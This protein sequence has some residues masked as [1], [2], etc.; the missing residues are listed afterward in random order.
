MRA[1]L[2][3]IST[4]KING[5]IIDIDVQQKELIYFKNAGVIKLR[6]VE[7]DQAYYDTVIVDNN[8]NIN[9][10]SVSQKRIKAAKDYF[11]HELSKES[12]ES[13]EQILD[14]LETTEITCIELDGKK[15]S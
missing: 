2:N 13:L 14:K 5:E 1:L 9:A 12:T 15:D 3:T 8:L 7:Y 4:R 6:P 10:N 11:E